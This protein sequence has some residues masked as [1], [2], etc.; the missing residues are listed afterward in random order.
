MQ[1]EQEWS[2]FYLGK[3]RYMPEKQIINHFEAEKII[4]MLTSNEYPEDAEK[5]IFDSLF[6]KRDP[7]RQEE[8]IRLVC[9]SKKKLNEYQ[10]S[11][12]EGY[13]FSKIH[14]FN[15]LA[16]ELIIHPRVDKKRYM[17]IECLIRKLGYTGPITKSTLF[18]APKLNLIID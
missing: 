18:D 14:L 12:W 2:K 1:Q 6:I 9:F 13:L 16:N 7:F 3:V 4:K 5:V 11:R 17:Q 8:E 15:E 10:E